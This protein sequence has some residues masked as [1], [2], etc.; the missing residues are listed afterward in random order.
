[1]REKVRQVV[2]D[3][4]LRA[5]V[6]KVIDLVAEI[7]PADVDRVLIH[8][9]IGSHNFAFD[10]VTLELRGLFDFEG[11]AWADRHW[12]FE[13][14]H[15]YGPAFQ[16]AVLGRYESLI[17]VCVSAWRIAVYHAAAAISFLACRV[18]QEPR[19]RSFGR[20]LSEDLNWTSEAVER[21]LAMQGAPR[22]R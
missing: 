6:E 8:G 16:S 3:P 13:Y 1:M 2:P 15:S 22:D 18:D 21:V 17:R 10:P 20:N 11:A 14:L 12:D 5:S 4:A 7:E 9:D 19:D